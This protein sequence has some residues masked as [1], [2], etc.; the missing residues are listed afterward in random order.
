MHKSQ[1]GGL[2]GTN[3]CMITVAVNRTNAGIWNEE[4]G[5]DGKPEFNQHVS[6]YIVNTVI[7]WLTSDPANKFFG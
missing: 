6:I 1:R 7:P 5:H 3:E 2:E 4:T